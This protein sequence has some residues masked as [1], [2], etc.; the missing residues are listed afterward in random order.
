[1]SC[2][3]T[4]IISAATFLGLAFLVWPTKLVAQQMDCGDFDSAIRRK[5]QFLEKADDMLNGMSDKL[6]ESISDPAAAAKMCTLA[7]ATVALV[8]ESDKLID[9]NGKCRSADPEGSRI[10]VDSHGIMAQTILNM[11]DMCK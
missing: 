2:T 4:K 9:D 10:L 8:K 7:K 11:K 3:I 5:I 1:M 6:F